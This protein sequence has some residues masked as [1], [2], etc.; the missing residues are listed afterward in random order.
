M[1]WIWRN[2]PEPNRLPYAYFADVESII[3][4]YQI[5]SG[6][7][8]MQQGPADIVV[9]MTRRKAASL[10]SLHCLPNVERCPLI[11]APLREIVAR[12]AGDEVQFMPVTVRAKDGDVTRY[13]FARPLNKIP[14][15]DLAESEITDWIVP[16]KDILFAKRVV[17][18]SDCLGDRHIVRDSYT[19][20]V[21]VSDALKDALMATGDKGL[22]FAPPII[23]NY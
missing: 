10:D 22:H 11:D 23:E 12:F 15:V 2:P 20:H 17:F 18:R 16:D 9:K 4:S 19:S 7:R 1:S 8:L 3:P 6:E 5:V 14:C 13:A 21:L